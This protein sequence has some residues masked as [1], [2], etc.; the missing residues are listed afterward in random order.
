MLA[1]D[2][3]LFE[4]HSI[5]ERII[6][7][8]CE[9]TDIKKDNIL[10]CATHLH[11]GAPIK[12][13]TYLKAD[14]P[15]I[16]MMVRLAADAITLANLRMKKMTAKYALGKVDSISYV[17][18]YNMK[19]GYAMTNPDVGNPDILE[20]C[21]DIDSDVPVLAFYDEADKPCGDIIAFACHQD[22]LCG[23]KCAYSTDF[24]GVMDKELKKEYG[25]SFVSV[26][27]EGTC[28]NINHHDV[29]AE[30]PITLEH[31]RKMGRILACE[32][33]SILPDACRLES[34]DIKIAKQ[35]V[36]LIDALKRGKHVICDKPICTSLEE[37]DE[38]ERLSEEK[39]YR[40]AVC[41]I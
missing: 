3:C 14:I 20:P 15:Y 29:H 18:N 2:I 40:F 5:A 22:C 34:D 23:E 12:N 30:K 21:A 35:D 10:V 24:A 41:L 33:K 1:L 27:F 39:N 38:I 16:D 8:V 36:E 26:F 37:L 13:D 6:E 25:S 31:H 17:R 4:N 9:Y 19:G 11:T 7:R 32:V 28:G